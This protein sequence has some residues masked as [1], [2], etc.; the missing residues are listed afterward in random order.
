MGGSGSDKMK[1]KRV[2]ELSSEATIEN[3]GE[4][5]VPIYWGQAIN[6]RRAAKEQWKSGEAIMVGILIEGVPVQMELDTGAAVSLLPFS[7]YQ[8]KFR[9][10]PLQKA[11]TRLRTY[12]YRSTGEKISPRGEVVVNLKVQKNREYARLPLIVVDGRGPPLLGQNWLASISVNWH[13]IKAV[14]VVDE[15]RME[16]TLEALKIKYPQPWRNGLARSPESRLR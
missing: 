15:R 13:D 9:H 14:R 16:E 7:V 12:M 11:S 5:E 1:D 3:E 10:I 2:K 6:K 8:E 4:A